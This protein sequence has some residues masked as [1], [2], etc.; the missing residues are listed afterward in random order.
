MKLLLVTLLISLGLPFVYQLVKM[1]IAILSGIPSLI[2]YMILCGVSGVIIS[3]FMDD[4]NLITGVVCAL[5]IFL[6]SQGFYVTVLA[7]YLPGR[8]SVA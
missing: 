2:L 6:L 4:A 8:G 7:K 3:V 1:N 5:A